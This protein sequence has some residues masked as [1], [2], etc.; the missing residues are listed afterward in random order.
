MNGDARAE[1]SMTSS[2]ARCSRTELEKGTKRDAGAKFSMTSSER[3]IVI[4]NAP[5][6]PLFCH[7]ELVSGSRWKVEK[8]EKR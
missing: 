3:N 1:F 8:G 2:G 4:P 7:P 6:S 5:Y